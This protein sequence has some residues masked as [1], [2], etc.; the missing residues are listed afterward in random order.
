[1]TIFEEGTRVNELYVR[2]H[3]AAL[4]QEAAAERVAAYLRPRRTTPDGFT[5]P[6]VRGAVGRALIALGTAIAAS[7]G[8]NDARPG[9]S[10]G[11][12]A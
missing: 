5:R 7:P 4:Q 1:M 6:G 2:D 12:I 8:R 10:A 9:T 3:I 11:H